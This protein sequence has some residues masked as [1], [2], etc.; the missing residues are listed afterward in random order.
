M[1]L[2][3]EPTPDHSP[4]GSTDWSPRVALADFLKSHPTPGPAARV[5]ELA[6]SGELTRAMALDIA[7][8]ISPAEHNTYLG[9]LTDAILF[10][11]ERALSDYHLSRGELSELVKLKR[12]MGV[13]EG[14]LLAHR[15]ERVAHILQGEIRRLL[16]D[17]TIDAGETL[18]QVDLQEVFDLSYDEYR[19]L[20]RSAAEELVD[21]LVDEITA[22]GVITVEER[23]RFER[24]LLALDIAYNIRPEAR[25]RLRHAGF[26][27]RSSGPAD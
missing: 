13:A 10:A 19:L 5:I 6:A 18:H 4:G 12:L 3:P 21:A 7:E 27:V 11:I 23:A 2:F 22:D 9:T 17:R 15:P 20:T 24:Q 26:D 14:D 16:A 1:P 25:E 8:S